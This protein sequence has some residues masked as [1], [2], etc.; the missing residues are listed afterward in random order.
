MYGTEDCCS[1]VN[2]GTFTCVYRYGTEDC[3]SKVN[4]GANTCVYRYGTE[5]CSSKV[6]CETITCVYRYGTEDCCSKVDCLVANALMIIFSPNTGQV[7]N[8]AL[9][10]FWIEEFNFKLPKGWT[11][12]FHGCL[13]NCIILQMFFFPKFLHSPQF[14]LFHSQTSKCWT[15]ELSLY[16]KCWNVGM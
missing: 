8:H 10:V 11:I 5:D 6:N 3:S 14:S 15:K 1:K 9:S 2:C 4:C 7:T 13:K 16:L 12:L